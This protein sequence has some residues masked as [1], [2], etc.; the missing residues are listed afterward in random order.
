VKDSS[1]LRRAGGC[2]AEGGQHLPWYRRLL[3]G[4][5]IGPTGA[6]DEDQVYMSRA[7]G[8][9]IVANLLRARAEYGVVFMKDHDFA[10]YNSRVARPCPN[11]RG[12]DLLKECLEEAKRHELPLIAYCQVQYDTSSWRSRPEWRM[13]DSA[14]Q[15]IPG[16]LCYC[17]GYLGFVQAC[18]AEMMEYDIAGFHF[19]MLDFGFSPPHGCW[20]ETCKREFERAYGQPMPPGVTWDEA[21]DKML[22]F[23]CASNAGF[24]REL[25]AFVKSRRPELSVDFN[26]HGY[27][28]FNW[29]EGQRP[30]QHAATGDFVTAEGLP[31][32][33]GHANPSLLSLFMAGARPGGPCQ[34]VTSRS[35]YD[36]HDFTVRPVAELKWETLTYLAHGAQCTIVDKANYDGTLD[37]VAFER[38]G[39]VFAEARAKR[40]YFGHPPVVEVG[41]YY[42]SRS[43]DWY[44]REDVS[45]YLAA[46]SGAHKA[47]LQAHIPMGIMMDENLSLDRLRQFPVVYLPNAAILTPQEIALLAEYAAGGG[48]LLITGLAGM[49]DRY[50]RLREHSDLSALVGA[51]LAS[52]ITDHLDNYIRL[53][54]AL[55][56]GPG[57][58][59]LADIPA[60]WPM[61]TWGPAA[62][63]EPDGAQAFGEIL[64]AH[65]SQDNQWSEH[66]SANQAIGPAVLLN[67]YGNGRVAYVP[68]QPDAAFAGDYRTPEHRT[69][70]RNL[71]RL[72]NPDPEVV[73]EAPINVE[74]VVTRDEARRR[75]LVHLLAFWPPATS[76]AASFPNGRRVL[77]PVMEQELPYRA[78]IHVNR[79]FSEAAAVGPD[80]DLSVAGG[81]IIIDTRHVHEV[82]V[83]GD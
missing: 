72:L 40:E 83:I 63:F 21:W 20:C 73:I 19:D 52:C 61:L 62:A 14:G 3:V 56:D 1:G 64:A 38:I 59:L 68:C 32:V 29:V 2:T 65:R 13:R 15:D 11:L 31:F 43:R 8:R 10:Y 58:L 39:Q 55:E 79:P 76:S 81:R 7:T 51:R 35:I 16:R 46:F 50:G 75:L 82:V 67:E 26:Y 22:E 33:F 5:E 34:G 12:R 9:E 77:P 54:A 74:A 4:I 66:M 47:L 44:G 78:T 37:P 41:L 36:Y 18:A 70:L 45:R 42:C 49:F 48:K 27:P 57:R 25:E 53:P 69:L 60:D 6:N 30:V 80:N 23:R 71:V 28:P 24:C 17:S